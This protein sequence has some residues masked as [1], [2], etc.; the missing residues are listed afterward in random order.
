MLNN[1]HVTEVNITTNTDEVSMGLP[2]LNLKT[3]KVVILLQ[4]KYNIGVLTENIA[5]IWLGTQWIDSLKIVLFLFISL[6]TSILYLP[7]IHQ[8]CIY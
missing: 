2:L 8:Y 6:A 7:S 1:D 3:L 4:D 5:F